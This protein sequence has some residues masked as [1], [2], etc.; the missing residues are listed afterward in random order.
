[1][2]DSKIPVLSIREPYATLIIE[3]KNDI[4]LRNWKP[5][6]WIKD[7][8]IHVPTI[9]DLKMCKE[10][11]ITSN[12]PKTIIGKALVVGVKEY[13]NSKDFAEDYQRHHSKSFWKYNSGFILDNV[14]KV[15]PPIENILGKPFF[16]FL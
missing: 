13:T 3:G 1:M 7:F 2:L 15:E 6:V 12:I 9:A 11:D 5:P 8:Y 4:E 14:E 10:Y 16:F